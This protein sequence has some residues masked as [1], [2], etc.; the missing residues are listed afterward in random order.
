MNFYE[1]K[2]YMLQ[3]IRKWKYAK[4][5]R[6]GAFGGLAILSVIKGGVLNWVITIC[7]VLISIV[8]LFGKPDVK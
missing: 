5:L 2:Y 8:C 4:F 7:L 6:G 1:R 3:K